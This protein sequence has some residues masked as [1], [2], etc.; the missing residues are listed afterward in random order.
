MS[1]LAE[2]D[3]SSDTSDAVPDDLQQLWKEAID[4]CERLE[5]L[6]ADILRRTAQL[7]EMLSEEDGIMVTYQGVHQD[8]M[9]VLD[10][11]H[12]VIQEDSNANVGSMLST[13]LDSCEF[14]PTAS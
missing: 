7:Q 14:K 9:N 4:E 13:M 2:S 11:I 8:L 3:A 1:E 6:H 5:H 12:A 10:S